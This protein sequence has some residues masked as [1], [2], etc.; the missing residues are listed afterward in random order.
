MYSG[1]TATITA[2]STTRATGREQCS[3]TDYGTWSR[4]TEKELHQDG[5]A[6]IPPKQRLGTGM[7]GKTASVTVLYMYVIGYGYN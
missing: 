2:E 5:R 3:R 4:T 6:E 1:V 7:S